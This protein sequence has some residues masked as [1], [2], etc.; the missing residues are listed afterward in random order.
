MAFNKIAKDP[1]RFIG[2]FL[3]RFDKNKSAYRTQFESDYLFSIQNTRLVGS[4]PIM[5]QCDIRSSNPQ[6]SF[7]D[8]EYLA[9]IPE[10]IKAF[11]SGLNPPSIYICTNA[12]PKFAN[13]ILGHIESPFI[14][15]TGDSDLPIDRSDLGSNFDKIIES[16]FLIIWFAQNKAIEHRK[17]H[18]LPIG[19]DF[20]SKWVDPQMW[21]EGFMLPA[22]QELELRKALSESTPWAE[23]EPKA[24]CDWTFSLDRG[25]RKECKELI[26]L[27]ACV[28]PQGSLSRTMAW[29]AQSH[30]SFVI[31]P[32]GAGLDCH[33]TWEALA[34]G[35]VPI[36]KRHP[37]SD[38]FD[39]MPVIIVD[40]WSEITQSFLKDQK[41]KL[42]S[43]QFDYSKVFLNFWTQKIRE[44]DAVYL[45]Y[46]KMSMSQF[47]QYICS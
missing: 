29:Q 16:P 38:L 17:L 18:S 30:Y 47:R 22:L 24:Y 27:A 13:E 43:M 7:I 34:L 35:C 46:P 32:S 12:L 40:D 1:M 4:Y 10:R 44:P 33:R 11:Q 6:S 2:Q 26:E 21:G 45:G 41:I 3:K 42:V 36:V 20:H 28:F 15:V 25:D 39:E 37:L 31:S 8:H 23:R 9:Q 5:S 19:L 14:L